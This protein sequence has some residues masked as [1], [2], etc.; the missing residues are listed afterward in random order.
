[1]VQCPYY[2][3]CHNRHKQKDT[4]LI[5]DDVAKFLSGGMGRSAKFD[6]PGDTVRGTI[7]SADVRQ[8][9][10]FVTKKP[11]FYDDGNPMEQLVIALQTGLHEDEDD[12]GVRVVYCKG[13]KGDPQ[14]SIGALLTAVKQAGAT[15]IAEGGTLVVQFTGLGVPT[16]GNPPKQ[17]AMAYAPPAPVQTGNLLEQTA[18]QAQPVQPVQQLQAPQVA[19]QASAPQVAPVAPVVPQQAPQALPDPAALLGGL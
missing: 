4:T 2:H 15:N 19:Q 10:D 16:Q 11:K 17:W 8:Q 14:S 9:T 3:T 1:M 6:T 7:L 18:P 13:A 5:S 12:D